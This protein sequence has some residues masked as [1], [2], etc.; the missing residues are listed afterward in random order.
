MDIKHDGSLFII[1]S[2]ESLLIYKDSN[3]KFNSFTDAFG[4]YSSD[5]GR[6][7]V[8][9]LSFSKN[10]L[11]YLCLAKSG[12]MVSTIK[13]KFEFYELIK[14]DNYPLESIENL[15]SKERKALHITIKSQSGV[16]PKAAFKKIINS[17]LKNKPSLNNEIERIF[18]LRELSE[19]KIKGGN[20][21]ILLQERE[22]FGTILD[23]FSGSN[24]LREDI[25]R[26]WAPHRTD[27]LEINDEKKSAVLKTETA[28]HTSFYSGLPE[29]LFSEEN[30]LQ[31]D[32]FNYPAMQGPFHSAGVSFFSQGDRRLEIIYANRN[33]LEKTLGVDLIYHNETYN[34]FT[35]VQYKIMKQENEHVYRPDKNILDELER[36][37]LFQEENYTQRN[38]NHDLKCGNE[39]R[40]NNNGFFIKL[41]P[42]RGLTPSSGELIKGMYIHNEYMNFLLGPQGPRGRNGGKL[43]TF[44]NAPRYLTNTDFTHF[45]NNGWIGT[46]GNATQK[47]RDLFIEYVTCGHSVIYTREKKVQ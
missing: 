1:D 27:L 8:S 39:F 32:L 42:N 30:A 35:L 14:L 6:L 31:H 3:N 5:I 46:N 28:H 13:R 43:I 47:V 12:R 29:R 26:S 38:S 33:S 25:L 18:S 44:N 21:D 9:I 17:I 10:N 20:A 24:K 45:I 34:S 16:I 23:I 2:P 4:I 37:N 22:A 19:Y 36:M 40:L 7:S 41:I 15:S 11:D